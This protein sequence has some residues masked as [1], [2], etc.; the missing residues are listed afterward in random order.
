MWDLV[1]SCLVV[2]RARVVAAAMCVCV[3]KLASSQPCAVLARADERR[4][5]R[6]SGC[7]KCRPRCT[8]S[9]CPSAPL[10]GRPRCEAFT[11]DGT[12]APE[13]TVG[14]C[15][16][17][18][19]RPLTPRPPLPQGPRVLSPSRRIGRCAADPLAQIR[20]HGCP[21]QCGFACHPTT[22]TRAAQSHY[23]GSVIVWLHLQADH[24]LSPVRSTAP[25]PIYSSGGRLT[26]APGQSDIPRPA[27]RRPSA[28]H[29]VT[30]APTIFA[31]VV[32]HPAHAGRRCRAI[33]SGPFPSPLQAPAPSCYYNSRYRV[34]VI[35]G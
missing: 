21:Q 30:S 17:S 1:L 5:A 13:A 35:R 7:S 29:A 15:K 19:S 27:G 28:H 16:T 34:Q 10:R 32:G 18:Q 26:Y 33:L 25:C 3:C 31:Q 22:C 2:R 12:C 11:Q 23:H 8:V 20:D 9:A 6:W 4:C 24:P 14:T